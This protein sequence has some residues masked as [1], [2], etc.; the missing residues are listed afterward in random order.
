MLPPGQK[1]EVAGWSPKMMRG[2]HK[3]AEATEYA[4][5]YDETGRRFQKSGDMGWLDEDG[6]LHLLDRKKDVIIS[7]GFNIYAIDLENALLAFEEV[8]EAAVIGAPSEAWGKR[9]SRLLWPLKGLYP[10]RQIC[11]WKK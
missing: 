1:G 3:R 6:F 8:S 9:L 5:W 10:W 4:S 11:F 2:Y 7:G